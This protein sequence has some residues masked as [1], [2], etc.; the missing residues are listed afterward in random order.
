MK[1]GVGT[2]FRVPQGASLS[3][4]PRANLTV[5]YNLH[6]YLQWYLLNT[7]LLCLRAATELWLVV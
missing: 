1:S 5:V 3:L 4:L 2:S 7:V 6:V